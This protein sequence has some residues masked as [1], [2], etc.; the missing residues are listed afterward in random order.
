MSYPPLFSEIGGRKEKKAETAGKSFDPGPEG[1]TPH[2]RGRAQGDVK[3]Q[4]VALNLVMD[5][6]SR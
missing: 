5:R 1:S 3:T 4:R 6:K 2:F